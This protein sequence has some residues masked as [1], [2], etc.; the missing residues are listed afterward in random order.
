MCGLIVPLQTADLLP[1]D[2]PRVCGADAIL[3]LR[4][5]SYG[6]SLPR[7]R[8]GYFMSCEFRVWS[9]FFIKCMRQR[10]PILIVAIEVV[11]DQ[12]IR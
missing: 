8:G 7:V 11:Q 5:W 1:K 2:H 12:A 4:P 10:L 6:G 3:N 9:S